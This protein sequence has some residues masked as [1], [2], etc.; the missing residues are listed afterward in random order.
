MDTAK[1]GIHHLPLVIILQ[2]AVAV[3][4]VEV[5]LVAWVVMAVGEMA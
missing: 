4:G 1:A 3:A 2:V 5:L